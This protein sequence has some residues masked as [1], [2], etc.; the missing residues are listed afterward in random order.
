MKLFQIK[1][2]DMLEFYTPNKAPSLSL[3]FYES[4]VEAG[5]PSPADDYI[6]LTLDLNKHLIRNPSATFYVRVRGHSM[7]NAGIYDGDMLIVDR[8]L[9][10]K[11]GDVAVCVLNG[12]FTVKRLKKNGGQIV[13]VPENPEFPEMVITKDDDF[14]IWGIVSYV[15]HKP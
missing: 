6:E 13:L 1:K 14:R 9:D 3:P 5:F 2:S 10:P 8:S 11:D 4:A 15:I 12:E 7:V